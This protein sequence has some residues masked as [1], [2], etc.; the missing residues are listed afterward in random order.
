M[1]M[2]PNIRNIF[3]DI[4]STSSINVSDPL[5]ID[6][7]EQCRKHVGTGGPNFNVVTQNIRSINKNF[8]SFRILLN[9]LNLNEDLIV[10]TECFLPSVTDL[11]E[12]ENYHSFR[13]VKSLNKN[14]G[15]VVYV[16]EGFDVKVYEPPNIEE[17]TCL[18]LTYKNEYA[19]VCMYRSPAHTNIE[20]FMNSVDQV[21]DGIRQIQQII[22]I[23][24]INIDIKID[25]DDNRSSDYLNLLAS[26]GLFSTHYLTTHDKKCLDHCFVKLRSLAKTIV[27]NS[28]VTDHSSII[29]SLS[30][31]PRRKNSIPKLRKKVNHD[32]VI[33]ELSSIH[34]VELLKDKSSNDATDIFLTLVKNAMNNHTTINPIPRRK[35]TM[36]P[37]VTPGLLRCIKN[38]DRLHQKLKKDSENVILRITYLRYRNT[39]NKT[40]KKLKNNYF[41][42]QMQKYKLNIRKQWECIKDLCYLNKNKTVSHELLKVK[43]TAEDSINNINNYFC[44]IG[45]HLAINILE[46]TK[47][48]LDERHSV[49]VGSDLNSLNSFV[50]LATDESEVKQII[51]NLKNSNS[52]G[53]DGIPSII[54]KLGVSILAAPITVIC[55]RCFEEG[56]FPNALKK[57]VLVPIHKAG[58]RDEISN[59][60]P[61]SLLPTLS[62][63]LEKIIDKRMKDYLRKNEILSKHQFGFRNNISTSDAVQHLTSNIVKN[64]DTN[65][66][67]LAIFLDLAKAF[68]TVSIPLL[69]NKLDKVGVRGLQHKLFTDYLSNRTQQVHIGD[70]I[71]KEE[72]IKFGVPQGSILG[73]TLFLIYIND[74]CNLQLQNAHIVTFADD[75]V[76][77][78]TGH[79]WA[80]TNLN[81]NA[82]FNMVSNWLDLNLLTLNVSKTKYLTFSIRSDGQPL[83]STIQIV[84]HHCKQAQ[85]CSCLEVMPATQI[86]YLGVLLDNHLRWKPHIKSLSGRL[87]KLIYV[88]KT[89][90]HVCDSSQLTSVYY[91]LGQSIITYCISSWGGCPKSTLI[92][93]ERAQRAILKIMTFKP[94]RYPTIELYKDTPILTVRQYFLMTILLE[95]HK[96][97][98]STNLNIRRQDLVYRKPLCKTT[99]AQN[100]A[101]FL[102]PFIYNKISKHCEL[103]TKLTFSCRNIIIQYLKTMSYDD[104]ESFIKP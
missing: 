10:L 63:I 37:W 96:I 9:R 5:L 89:L 80:E 44:N 69:L 39:C 52:T 83:P 21:I 91:A 73:P 102:G 74:L 38:R 82:G 7:P 26:H 42:S 86:K 16:K 90:R 98:K 62:K 58:D 65:K 46:R 35:R 70:Y 28:T 71:S 64:L 68:D 1:I 18:V 12:L 101:Q 19:F 72:N 67:C 30:T 2:M 20:K 4:D 81:A 99:F 48:R 29:L 66:K 77:L 87:R 13:T 32:A 41:R 50:L 31:G 24:D 23:G 14:D 100:F 55:N 104:I 92:T 25:N 17:V 60:R 22:L 75:T 47:E 3:A 40:L 49:S 43:L 34:W 8:D 36:K 54:F 103:R 78:F 84:S 97:P 88:F 33:E 56:S 61:I 15:V 85:N 57:S 79:S 95:Q 6:V 76:L 53:W 59:Y 93:L 27:C 45:S 11:P 94:Y 51:R